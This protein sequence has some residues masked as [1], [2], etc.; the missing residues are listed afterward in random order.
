[1]SAQTQTQNKGLTDAQKKVFDAVWAVQS[2]YSSKDPGQR[3]ELWLKFMRD[4]L[5]YLPDKPIEPTV[6][7]FSTFADTSTRACHGVGKTTVGAN[8]LLT[9]IAL[10]P[11][12]VVLQMSPTWNQVKSIFWNE[13][14]KWMPN[15]AYMMNAFDIAEKAPKLWSRLDDKRWYAQGMASN[16]PGKIEGKHGKRVVL[17]LDECKAIPDD[18]IEAVMGALTSEHMWR[19]ALSTPSTPG[20]KFTFFY[21]TFT[22]NRHLWKNHVISADDSPRVSRKWVNMMYEEYGEDSQI[23]LARVK[24][25]FPDIAGDI[26][27]PLQS[28]EQFY[29]EETQGRGPVSIGVDIA[30]FGDDECVAS[31]WRGDTMERL[32]ILKFLNQAKKTTD[33]AREVKKLVVETDARVVVVDDIGVGGG[34][35]DALSDEEGPYYVGSNCQV[36][37]FVSSHKAKEDRKFTSKWDEVFYYFA[38]EI[39]KGG[40][41]SCID[42][43]KLVGQLSSF[44]KNYTAKELIK[45]VWPEKSDDR[46][47]SAKSP[48]RA[49]A[50]CLGWYGTRLLW[51]AGYAE[52]GEK[53]TDTDVEKALDD[54]SSEFDGIGQKDF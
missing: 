30:R 6:R 46:S 1:M 38:E 18:M 43:E 17:I 41:K 12:L 24:A 39:I 4:E 49:V 7:D 48:D 11:E 20:G 23:V 16:M 34:V 8:L 36:V 28:A 21:K 3:G 52:S 51:S 29:Q 54:L 44:K 26:V 13:I 25:G 50:S 47:S 27:I 2:R 32:P 19:L 31:I 37:P 33:T 40:V 45:I 15:S 22:R 14:R 42:D 10:V 9:A 53:Q 35:T 5:K